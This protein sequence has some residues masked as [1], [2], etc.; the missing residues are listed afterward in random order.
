MVI[1]AMKEI[2]PK[3]RGLSVMEGQRAIYI[4]NWGRP[5]RDDILAEKGPAVET[6]GCKRSR[7]SKYKGPGAGRS[8]LHWRMS[9]KVPVQLNCGTGENR[10]GQRSHNG[11]IMGLPRPRPNAWLLF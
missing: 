9:K 10:R 5:L 6:P 7:Q 11:W 1:C 2:M 8:L 3:V 4:G